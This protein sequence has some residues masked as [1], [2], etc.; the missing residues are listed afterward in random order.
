MRARGHA[1]RG[2]AGVPHKGGRP[3]QELEA[4]VRQTWGEGDRDSE[5]DRDREQHT[6]SKRHAQVERN[7][8]IER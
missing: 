6:H 2:D 3:R 8:Q 7:R 4:Q 5:R 1:D